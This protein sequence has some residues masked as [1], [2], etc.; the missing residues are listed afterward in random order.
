M[1]KC[2]ACLA[3]GKNLKYQIQKDKSGKLKTLT[4]LGQEIQIDFSGKLNNKK[5][6]RGNQI[7]VAIDSF[8]KCSTVKN[9]RTSEREEVIHFQRKTSIFTEYRKRSNRIKAEFLIP[10]NTPNFTNQK[11]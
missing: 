9:C 7:L 1:T 3:S 4:E 2:V 10:K 5:L 11:T 6:N 8:S